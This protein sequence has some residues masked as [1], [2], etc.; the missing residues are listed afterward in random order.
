MNLSE[1]N[2]DV[3][4]A[5]SWP[6]PVKAATIAIISLF[7]AGAVVYYDTLPLTDELSV[8]EAKEIELRNTFKSK[9]GK[10]PLT[11][12]IIKIN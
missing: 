6:L 1:I 5:G 9:Q 3:N 8:L 12:R 2:W 7:V 11:C 4:V 10:K